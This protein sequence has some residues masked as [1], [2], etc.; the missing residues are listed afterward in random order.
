MNDFSASLGKRIKK[1]SV[2][3]Q[4]IEP[5][6]I[7]NQTGK[8]QESKSKNLSRCSRILLGYVLFHTNRCPRFFIKN[9]KTLINQH[10]IACQES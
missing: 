2:G 7:L 1:I 4:M 5:D 3:E 6:S 8:I 9:E 10:V